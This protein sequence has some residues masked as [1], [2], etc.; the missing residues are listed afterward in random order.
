MALEIHVDTVPLRVA[1]NGVVYIG[2]T[3]V[4]LETVIAAYQLGATPEQIVIDYDALSLADTYTV[5]AY[6]LNHRKEIDKYIQ[7]QEIRSEQV[8]QEILTKNPDLVG[9]R[10]RLL[11]RLKEKQGES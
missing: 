3:R 10:E 8:R 5:I 11:E 2:Q 1:D 4:T 7:Q 9:L 6:Y